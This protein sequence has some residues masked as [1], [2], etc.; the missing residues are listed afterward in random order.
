MK[1]FTCLFIAAC[2]L[3]VCWGAPDARINP[4]KQDKLVSLTGDRDRLGGTAQVE[5]EYFNVLSIGALWFPNISNKGYIGYSDISA[6]YPGGGDVSSV[7][8]AG[9]WAGGYV[10]GNANAWM[11]IGA[12]GENSDPAQFDMIDEQAIVETE[13]DFDPSYPYPYR[14]LTVHVNSAAKDPIPAGCSGDDCTDGDL[15]MDVTYEWH[16]WGVPGYDNWV[17]VHLTIEFSKDISEFYLGWFSD[18]DVG[19]VNLADY[20]FDDYA[21]WDDTYKFCYMRDWDY[22]PLAPQLP[23][24]SAADSLWLTPNVVGQ[25]LLA[26][27]S[28]E[29]EDIT[30]EP[31]STQKWVSKNFWDWNNDISSVQNAYDRVAGI[32]EN[33]FPPED[34]FDYRILN[35]V[36][37]YEVTAGDVAEFWVA[38]VIGEGYDEGSHATFDMGTLVEHVVDAQAFYDGGMTIPSDEHSPQAP[39]LDP[40]FAVD[41]TADQLTVHWDP[42]TNIAGGAVADSFIVY[43]NKVSKMGPWE[44]LAAFDNTVTDMTIQLEPPGFYW[45]VWVQAYDDDNGVGSNPWALTSRLYETDSEGILQANYE[46]IVGVLGST[47]AESELDEITVAPN[48]YVGSNTGELAEYET[49]LG[50]HHLPEQC[51]IYIYNLLGN[52][53]DIIHHNAATG[54]EFWDMTTR[55][56]ESISSGLYMYRVKDANGNEKVGKFAVI[57]GQR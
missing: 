37:P 16:Q 23:A 53:V 41:V 56:G 50:F 22:D 30:A 8:Q 19:D 35:G 4:L 2:L 31:V 25:I 17:F 40:D 45:Y 6:Y 47:P 29:G 3:L 5:D 11:Y 18:C 51:T 39:D 44:R 46:T 14:R 55:S 24:E 34:D 21:G 28:V 9:M 10:E 36:G 49:L 26:A 15:G 48:P 33:P 42:Y 27:P 54:S 38:Y 12:D 13:A 43:A 20:Y 1:R 57:K 32:W 7:W 52:L